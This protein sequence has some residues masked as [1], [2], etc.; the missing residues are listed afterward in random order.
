MRVGLG[1]KG[2]AKRLSKRASRAGV[3]LRAWGLADGSARMG[4]CKDGGAK[5]LS[6]RRHHLGEEDRRGWA[7]GTQAMEGGPGN[8]VGVV[9]QVGVARQGAN[10]STCVVQDWGLIKRSGWEGRAEQ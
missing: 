3:R 2:E 10:A 1:F 4:V 8:K 5:G 7:S 6:F 9:S